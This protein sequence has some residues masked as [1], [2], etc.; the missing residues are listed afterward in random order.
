[1]ELI[2]VI[3]AVAIIII[4]N[5]RGFKLYW[6]ILTGIAVV[7]VSNRFSLEEIFSITYHSLSSPTMITLTLIVITL[8]A[9]GNLMK[10]TGSLKITMLS[11]SSLVKDPRYQMVILPLLIGLITFPGGAVFSAPLVE[12][13]GKKL[14]LSRER[15]VVAN[16][17]FRHVQY[18][19]YPLYPGL[20]L[21]AEISPYN[22]YD[23]IYFNLPVFAIFFLVTFKYVF[24]GVNVTGLAEGGPEDNNRRSELVMLLYSISPLILIILLVLI[25]DL[26]YPAAILSGILAVFF[27]YYPA[28]KPFWGTARSRFGHLAG[29]I[30]WSMTFS[31]I[32][33]LIFKDFLE[34]SEVIDNIMA[35]MMESN[36]PVLIPIIF[37]PFLTAFL[38]GNYF[39]AVGI[40]VPLFVPILPPGEQGFYYMALVFLASQAGYFGSP[41]HMCNILTIEHFKASLPPVIKD[42]NILGTALVLLGITGFLV[43]QYLL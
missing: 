43:R 19:I 21:M 12:E 2:G 9:F 3:A 22:L 36:F 17:A 34:H 37:L 1:M 24:R 30:N 40:C 8:T 28:E 4:M 25:F 39:A 15:M 38:M 13:A 41:I 7:V 31:I 42:V 23:Y 18:M 14:T 6:S 33:I 10:E 35:V 27:I 20:L 26:Y 32:T 29:G 5:Q 16:T 11:L